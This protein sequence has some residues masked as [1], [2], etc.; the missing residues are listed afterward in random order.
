MDPGTAVG[1]ASLG[2][3][4]CQALLAYYDDWKSYNAEISGTYDVIDD[5]ARTL[6]SLKASLENNDLDGE[7]RDRVRRCLQDSEQALRK[8]SEKLTKLRKHGQPQGLREKAWAEL[9]RAWYPFRASTL[10][11]LREIVADARERLKLAISVLHLDISATSQRIL[12]DVAGHTAQLVHRTGAM[13]TSLSRMTTQTQQILDTQ[14]S[15]RF[16]K[17]KSWLSAPDPWTN[18]SA[19]RKR[20]E[21][22]T[23]T[24]LLR[25]NEYQKWKAGEIRH[26]WLY[27]QAG[28]GKTVLCSTVVEDI[29]SFC[30]STG[31]ATSAFFYFT[32]SEVRKQSY[33]N[34]LLSLV[35][36]LAW[37]EPTLSTLAQ[38]REK[39]DARAPGLEELEKI[40]LTAI[41]AC[42]KLY[43]VLDALDE[44][45]VDHDVRQNVLEGLER[46]VCDVYHVQ[47]LVTS[48]EVTQVRESMNVVGARPISIATSAVN[49]D[50][51]KYTSS[52]LSRDRNLSKLDPTMKQLVEDT[53]TE[54]AGGM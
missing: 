9:Q 19:A 11:K 22:D 34:L 14:R 52:Q 23:G 44:S 1:V 24:W 20:H 18:H 31:T 37:K 41:Q 21:P 36:Q 39:P 13:E 32:F 48:R 49:S 47:V 4:V 35:E 7:K 16:Q 46:L 27:G 5:L 54:R 40:L 45:P 17:V 3:Q 2:I 6:I 26:L 8:L 29:R 15:D 12:K 33:E 50:I 25:S 43:L 30:D 53:I 28:C 38:A 51:K 10:A 42:S